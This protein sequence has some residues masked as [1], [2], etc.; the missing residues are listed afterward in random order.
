MAEIVT[1]IVVIALI[2]AAMVGLVLL[3]G[4]ARRRGTAGSAIAGAMAAYDEGMHGTAHDAF[5]EMQEQDER[6]KPV[7]A[8]DRP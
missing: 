5:V 3:A 6:V 8:P 1:A 4:R 7:E 2:A